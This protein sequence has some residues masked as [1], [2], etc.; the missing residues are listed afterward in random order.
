[1][2]QRF[3]AGRDA[4]G[5]R[6]AARLRGGA[7]A[8]AHQLPAGRDRRPR[9]F[10]AARRPAAAC[11]CV[12]DATDA[13]APHPAAVQQRRPGRRAARVAGRRAIPR[14]RPRLPAAARAAVARQRL[15]AGAARAHQGAAQRLRPHHAGAA[16]RAE[17]GR[18]IPGRRPAR[19]MCASRPARPGC[20]SPTRCCT[21]RWPG[22]CALEQTFHLPVAAMAHPERSPLRVLER[23]AGR[24]LV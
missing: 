8:R 12:P 11:R 9:L 16:R 22:H 1:M 18:R 21:P 7:R 2:M 6:P 13:R 15:G 10:A 14:L 20:A 17:A 4:A 23:L 3:A 5:G 19:P 24:A